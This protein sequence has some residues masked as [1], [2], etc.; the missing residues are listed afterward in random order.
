MWEHAQHGNQQMLQ[1]RT[2]CFSENKLMVYQ[3][4]TGWRGESNAIARFF[5]EKLSSTMTGMQWNGQMYI[6]TATKV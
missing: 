1:T 3:H 4:T 6:K 5:R 2:F